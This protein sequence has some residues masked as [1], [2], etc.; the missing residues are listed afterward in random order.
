ME[1]EIWL[2]RGELSSRGEQ[3]RAARSLLLNACNKRGINE[4]AAIEQMGG[5]ELIDYFR[6]SLDITLSIAH[7]RGLAAVSLSPGQN[8]IGVDCEPTSQKRNWTAIAQ[9]F[10]SPEEAE[11]ILKAT[12]HE[13]GRLFLQL[14]VLKEAYI[15][16]IGGSIFGDVNRLQVN[17]LQEPDE[18]QK[19]SQCWIW[20]AVFGDFFLGFCAL[21]CSRPVVSVKENSNRLIPPEILKQKI[22]C[23]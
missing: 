18:D 17:S 1:V 8:R 16:A 23:Y 19:Y 2:T 13:K 21:E 15:K 10:F 7:C 5:P 9:S 14:W 6:S 3:S 22:M 4:K 12:E 11:M 20:R